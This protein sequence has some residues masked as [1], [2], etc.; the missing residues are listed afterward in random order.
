MTIKARSSQ[1]I[2][3]LFF[4]FLTLLTLSS[5]VTLKD[6]ETSQE[7]TSAVV[8]TLEGGHSAGQS[9]IS[10]RA[11]LN[12]VFLWLNVREGANSDQGMLIVQLFHA[13]GEKTPLAAVTIPLRDA[14]RSNPIQIN[15]PVQSD[16][17]AQAYY[18]SLLAT[19]GIVDVL[20]RDEDAY[21]YGNATRDGETLEGDFAFRTSY[22]YNLSAF[23]GDIRTSSGHWWLIFPL[24][25]VLLLPG[26][27]IYAILSPI[28]VNE[29]SDSSDRLAIAVGL[30]MA[31]IPL[32]MAWT[33]AIKL[34][35]GR[36]GLLFAA[37]MMLALMIWQ[38]IRHK[39]NKPK[40]NWYVV[41]LFVIFATALIVRLIM[42]RDLAAPAWV[43][44][45]HHSLLTRIIME[46]GGYPDNY[47]PYID[48]DNAGYHPG[49]HSL[50]ASF[51]WLTNL[52]ALDAMKL[53]G[54]VLNALSVIAVYLF[55]KSLTQD[56][57]AG[58][59]AAMI[60]A[61]FTPM[62]AY[63]ASW[64]R[65]TQLAG[66]LILP[67]SFSLVKMSSAFYVNKKFV[68][69]PLL[70][71]A[72]ASAGLF[73][74]HYRVVVFLGC[75]LLADYISRSVE[76]IIQNYK[77]NKG[78]TWLREVSR[79]SLR[80]IMGIA[81]ITLVSTIL[82]LPWLPSA[83]ST[84]II[85]KAVIWQGGEQALFSGFSWAFL[86]TAWG[87][88]TLYLAGLGLIWSIFRKPSFAF[89]IIL[90]TIFLFFLANQDALGIF[91][92]FINNTSVE[93]GL[94]MPISALGG[95][96]ISQIVQLGWKVI[97]KQF[98]PIYIACL[99]VSGVLVSWIA[100]RQLL[101]IL[102]PVTF[103]FRQ[104]DQPALTWISENIPQDETVL[105]NPFNWGYGIYA[106]NDGGFW[107]TPIA[108]IRSMPPPV[109]YGMDNN[110]DRIQG[111]S[112][113]SQQIIDQSQDANSLHDLL[114]AHN[115]GYVYIGA[116]GGVLSPR[117]LQNNPL[118]QTLYHQDGTWVFQVK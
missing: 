113:F 31:F 91:P 86:T 3:L 16:P 64:G 81:L 110:V 88:Y 108:G 32:L 10:R 56:R 117:R 73:L 18:L 59:L 97:P 40:L 109:F 35:W 1:R 82:L 69:K 55:T 105:I 68:W 47:A 46:Q 92:S 67:V 104:A 8:A 84:F 101:P 76:E 41:I 98:K 118:Y 66:L 52:N 111:I 78:D 95:H 115:I 53:F 50:L 7:H 103:L 62:P 37:G 65:Y 72:V 24:A 54:Q 21:P 25:I 85:P 114:K 100:V 6:P 63:Y 13:P 5:C 116:R 48:I 42:V 12:G 4:S 30:S 107:I 57:L 61:Y 20:G 70:L 34:P 28:N 96:I 27:L 75:L 102:N 80:E 15:L 33:S 36:L 99:V 9:F 51:Q 14:A 26:W 17:P 39:G 74:T 44:S 22:D 71:A 89:T 23:W 19:S 93:I 90:W 11:R 58:L 79:I 49:F 29:Q 45:V 83:L 38:L 43:D 60:T 94:F 77:T 112:R 87:K 106:G 2:L